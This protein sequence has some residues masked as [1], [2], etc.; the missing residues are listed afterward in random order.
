[1][2][3]ET[4]EVEQQGRMRTERQVELDHFGCEAEIENGHCSGR[5]QSAWAFCVAFSYGSAGD[6]LIVPLVKP[7]CC[8]CFFPSDK[9]PYMEGEI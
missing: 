2:E 6:T 1:M 9:S 5:G 3:Y 4:T 8:A 7:F